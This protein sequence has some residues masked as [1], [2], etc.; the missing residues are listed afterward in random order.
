MSDFLNTHN[1]NVHRGMHVLADEATNIYEQ[2]RV[3]VQQF[4]NAKY[5]EEIIFTK[6]CTESLNM[7]AKCF[8]KS[9]LSEHDTVLL[10]ILEHHSAIVP[11]IQLKGEKNIEIAY[12]DIDDSLSLHLSDLDS[13]LAHKNIRFLSITA[14][15][16]VLGIRPPLKE[17][18]ERAHSMDIPVCVD[19]AQLVSHAPIDV[20]HLDCDFLTFSGHKLF[21]PTGIGVLYA[22]KEHQKNM[23]PWLGGGMMISDVQRDS[24]TPADPPHCFEGGTPPILQ[25]VGLTSAIEWL[26]QFSWEDIESHEKHLLNTANEVL[27]SI[28]GL[29]ILGTHEHMGCMSFTL[30]NVHPHDL[31]DILG[32]RGICLRAGHHC[33]EP[34]HTRLGISATTRLS[35]ALFN[36]EEEITTLAQ[37]IKNAMK[38]LKIPLVSHGSVR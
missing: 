5:P 33:T 14:L 15:S 18:I 8:G 12:W 37:E 34:L 31:T 10:S 36:T 2:A 9:H 23:S 22:K 30:N 19:A 6:S 13:L 25:A 16:N 35:V 1:A 3:T 7:V 28:P 20:Q 24:Y 26:S 29:S 11:W 27:S 4:I 32:Q 38:I 21:G 17:V